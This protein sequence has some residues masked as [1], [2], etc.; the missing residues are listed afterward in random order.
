MRYA[1][2]LAPRPAGTRC[3]FRG[4][5]AALRERMSGRSSRTPWQPQQPPLV[6]PPAARR[7]LAEVAVGWDGDDLGSSASPKARKPDSNR[8]DHLRGSPPP[9]R[10]R[11]R[12]RIHGRCHSSREPGPLLIRSRRPRGNPDREGSPDMDA[13]R[14]AKRCAARRTYRLFARTGEDCGYCT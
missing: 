1:A 6:D 3:C 13:T 8:S 4:F 11:A 2:V 7:P 5:S 10:R 14:A 12:C 9:N